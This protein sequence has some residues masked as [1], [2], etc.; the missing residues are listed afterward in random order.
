MIPSYFENLFLFSLVNI[1]KRLI[2]KLI[3]YGRIA[4]RKDGRNLYLQ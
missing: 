3:F 4:T 2:I 1:L